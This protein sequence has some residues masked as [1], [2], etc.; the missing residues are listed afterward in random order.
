MFVLSGAQAKALTREREAF[1]AQE[2]PMVKAR[3]ETLELDVAELLE[4]D[5]D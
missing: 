5:S 2:W 1:L 4:G 3:I